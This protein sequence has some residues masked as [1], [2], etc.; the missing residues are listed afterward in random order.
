MHAPIPS[1]QAANASRSGGGLLVLS[2]IVAALGS[3]LQDIGNRV[4]AAGGRVMA[5]YGSV[6][7]W[8]SP[9]RGTFTFGRQ[10][11]G[12]DLVLIDDAPGYP[13][14]YA[15]DYARSNGGGIPYGTEIDS[16]CTVACASGDSAS[17]CDLATFPANIDA[18]F[19][20]ARM[21]AQVDQTY[22]GGGAYVDMANWDFYYQ[23]AFPLFAASIDHAVA[24]AQGVRTSPVPVATQTISLRD[25]YIHHSDP[26]WVQ[27]LVTE[28]DTL[29]QAGP[30]A[31]TLQYDLDP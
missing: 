4:H 3:F 13:H 21:D 9:W 14:G 28:R 7:D 20:M 15:M 10:I 24:Q 2:A 16:P 12:Y 22:G 26:S 8:I 31:V 5:Q 1:A 29:A 6:F 17:C 30:V 27:S 18:D 11:A 23:T 25:L 19:G